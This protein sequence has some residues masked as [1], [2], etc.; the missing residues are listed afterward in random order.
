MQSYQ[1]FEPTLQSRTNPDVYK[2]ALFAAQE[3]VYAKSPPAVSTPELRFDQAVFEQ[4]MGN[5]N[6]NSPRETTAA[7]HINSGALTAAAGAVSSR[8]RTE[9]APTK[10]IFHSDSAAA[11]AAATI[12]HQASQDARNVLSDLEPSIEASRIHHIARANVRLYTSTPPVEIEVAEQKHRDTLRAAAI[13]MAKDMYATS[14][15]AR[16]EVDE[17]SYASIAAQNRLSH[18]FS[19]SQFSWT[20]G[21]EYNVAQQRTPNLHEAAQK[22][23]AEKLAKMQE[24]DLYNKQQYYGTASSPKSRQLLTRRLK[25][26]TSSEGDASLIDWERSERI[27]NQ[28]SSLQNRMQEV[29]EKKSQDRAYLMDVARKNVTATIHNMDEKVYAH[30]GKPSPKMQ[31]EWEEKAQERAKRESELRMTNFGRVSVGGQKYMDQTD[32]EAIA[33]SRIQP[34]LDEI[35][36]RAE[37]QRA[38]EV[39][40]RLDKERKQQLSELDRSRQAEIRAEDKRQNGENGRISCFEN[41]IPN[42]IY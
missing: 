29:D 15:A 10:P 28:M 18:R 22:I 40:Q 4:P 26:R 32:V 2:A 37:E 19:Q 3:R 9:S 1:S 41:I 7:A 13:S 36:N 20:P 6:R 27:R 5:E 12:S 42:N 30:T 23:A 25:R 8:R 35:S 14:T 31:R 21:D 34:T 16:L 38:R 17:T 33:R 11:L 39:E 24:N